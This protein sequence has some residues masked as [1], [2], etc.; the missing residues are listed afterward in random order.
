MLAFPQF[1]NAT[2]TSGQLSS[3]GNIGMLFEQGRGSLQAAY[4]EWE[5]KT[6]QIRR[7][8]CTNNN[9]GLNGWFGNLGISVRTV[10]ACVTQ[11][12]G[13]QCFQANAFVS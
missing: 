6:H 7:N 1:D 13:A 8:A 10:F 3:R 9:K 4:K 5:C 2:V 11:I 12:Y